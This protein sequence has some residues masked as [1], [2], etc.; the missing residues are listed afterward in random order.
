MTTCILSGGADALG[1]RVAAQLAAHPEVERLVVLDD[2]ELTS[3]DSKGRIEGA[4]VLVHLHG[5]LEETRSLLD[6][7][8]A[9][10]VR[11]TVVLSSATVYG[12]W[13]A[14][15]VPLTE[16]H[17]IKPNPELELGVRAAQ[18]ERLAA[19]WKLDHPGTTA[20]VLRPATPVAASA[21]GWL[22][23]GLRAAAAVRAA[24]DDDP[25]AQYVHLDDVASAVVL[26]ATTRLDGAFNVA[27]DGWILGEQLRALAGRPQ[28]RLPD[29]LAARAARLRSRLGPRSAHPGLLPYTRYPWVV[30]NGKLRSAGW[31]PAWTSEEAYVDA[32]PAAPWETVSPQRRQELALGALGA[33]VAGGVG[34]LVAVVRRRRRRGDAQ[35]RSA[36]V[37]VQR[38]RSAPRM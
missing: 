30:A 5:G 14:N 7:A 35:A 32:H 6:A 26:A 11:H 17:T 33:V 18:R 27:P 1:Q 19:E 3:P 21:L 25:P 15:P 29:R 2:G 9:V 28:L 12:A 24:G 37:G 13:E 10:G 16:E 31:A 20:A 22:A 34:W 4:D 38:R 8:G 36:S 23:E